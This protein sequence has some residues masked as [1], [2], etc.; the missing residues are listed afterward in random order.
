MNKIKKKIGL[1]GGTFNPIHFGHLRAAIETHSIFGLDSVLMIPSARPPHKQTMQK[2]S[3]QHRLTMVHLAIQ[4]TPQLALSDVEYQRQG[5]SYTVETIVELHTIYGSTAA[6]HL[7]IGLDAFREFDTW[8]RFRDLFEMVPII[9]LL[10]PGQGAHTLSQ[11]ADIVSEY[12]NISLS[13]R[14]RY[15]SVDNCFRHERLQTVYLL[16]VTRLDISSSRIREMINAGK[17][18]R[19]LLPERVAAYIE[20]QRLY[21]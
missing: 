5:P 12:L 14:Y 1:F 6:L 3:A 2:D 18:A 15:D 19:F 8:Y 7:I 10:R 21:L 13:N 17:P 4:E 11:A 20:K 16:E 9:V